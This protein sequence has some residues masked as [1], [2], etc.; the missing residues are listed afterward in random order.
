M[1]N[2]S[3]VGL[4]T[5]AGRPFSAHV[6]D[7]LVS[8]VPKFQRHFPVLRDDLTLVEVLE[9]AGRRI[10]RRE[11]QGGRIERLHGYAWVTLR[12]IATS[13]LRRGDGRMAQ[14]T[15]TAEEGEAALDATPT[16]EGTADHIERTILLREVLDTLTPDERLVCIWKKAGFSSQEIA[17]RR[18]G[19]AAAVDTMLSRVRQKVRRLLGGTIGG[20]RR[21]RSNEGPADT[22]QESSAP[23]GGED[24]N[25]NG[26]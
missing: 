3:R 10:E 11:D 12:S 8:L 25:P 23:A 16:R 4:V 18:G 20:A 15:L 1:D 21:E 26:R 6:E 5:E 17:N 19:T 24:E 7:A 13:R 14:R 9:E 2:R 22:G